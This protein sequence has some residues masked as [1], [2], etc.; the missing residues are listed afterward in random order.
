MRGS[1][2]DVAGPEEGT[3]Y[4][5]PGPIGNLR[6]VTLRVLDTLQ[7]ADL[8]LAEDTRRAR[9]LL[10]HY[11]IGKKSLISFF[12]GNE[13]KRTPQVLAALREG[14]RVALLSEAGTP[15]LSDPGL[16]LVSRVI[17]EGLRVE[18]LPGPSSLL[19]ALTLSGFPLPPFLFLGFLPR[20]PG[21]RRKI[22]TRALDTG[23]TFALFE[24]PGR[25]PATLRELAEEGGAERPCLLARELTKKH[26][27]LL[28][29]T[30]S[31]LAQRLAEEPLRGECVLVVGPSPIRSPGS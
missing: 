22:L 6:D 1:A 20:R 7:E 9:I 8:V 16:Y 23:W 17:E 24:A 28:R 27:E 31:S 2:P 26:E 12:A 30:C 29:G 4:L 11:G 10:G 25:V 5:C 21:K 18:A 3:L 19:P 13:K 14:K 15:G